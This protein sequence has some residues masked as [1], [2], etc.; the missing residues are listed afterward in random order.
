MP[1]GGNSQYE[2][3]VTIR[4]NHEDRQGHTCSIWPEWNRKLKWLYGS[5][6]Q[7]TEPTGKYPRP[8]GWSLSA[9]RGFLEHIEPDSEST[10]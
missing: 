9:G 2:M 4:L 6:K 7:V 1:Y 8:S 5:P 10:P 3:E